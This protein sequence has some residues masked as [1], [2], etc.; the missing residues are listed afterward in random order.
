MRSKDWLQRQKNDLYV[1]KA[2]KEGYFS[3]AAYKLIEIENKF[4]IVSNSK[5]NS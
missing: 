4:N 3:R 1:N 5:K 2:K